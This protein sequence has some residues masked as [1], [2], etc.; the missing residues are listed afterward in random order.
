MDASET[1]QR[2]PPIEDYAAIGNCHTVALVSRAGSID[3]WCPLRFDRSAVFAALLDVER[4]GRFQICPTAPFEVRRRYL[5]R[6]NVLE[7][8]FSTRQGRLR[9]IDWMPLGV[10][11]E[12]ENALQ[13][14]HSILRVVECTAGSVEVQLTY[15]PRFDYGKAVP[16]IEQKTYG[17]RCM[18]GAEALALRSELP[19]GI[20]PDGQSVQGKATLQ[21]GDRHFVGL[22]FARGEP[23]LLPPL[24]AAAEAL[25]E[26]TRRWW[27]EWAAACSYDGPYR[28]A[29]LRSALALKL[30]TYAPSGAIVAAP[31]TSLPEAV[32]GERNWD[33][34]Y[35]WLRDASLTMRALLGLGY[36][37]EA[38]AFLG[39]LLHATYVT[40][41][42]L[43][44]VYDVFGRTDLEE[45]V[46]DHLSGYR[47]SR[48]VRVGNE[49]GRQFQL[50]L[51]GEVVG[52]A[53]EYIMRGG[54]LSKRR[55]Q[56]LRR[57]GEV[58]CDQWRK[59]DEGIWEV[60]TGRRHYVHSKLMCWRALDNLLTM[61]DHG[62]LS[63]PVERFRREREVIRETIEDEGYSK[64][65]N[66][67]VQAFGNHRADASLL[68]LPLQGYIRP[69]APRMQSTYAFLE[70]QLSADGLWYRYPPGGGDGLEGR[71]GAFGVCSFWAVEYLARA[72]KR[73]V[74][75]EA[76]E[77]V[78]ACANDVGLFAEE[79]DPETGAALGNFPQ[80]FTH[81][82]LVN[83]AL[84]L[85]PEEERAASEQA[86]QDRIQ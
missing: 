75:A 42:R 9:L 13:P 20:A 60:R 46:L 21:H 35:C 71:E 40:W 81:I 53:H 48:P 73:E 59:P 39:W 69:T 49:A 56:S 65:V 85:A 74:A 11:D 16:R 12:G 26:T 82:G 77:R 33:Y 52:A 50:D 66:S 78:L 76:F 14:P 86:P 17:L 3:W 68:L 70:E 79:I 18:R 32:G 31:T 62:H 83:A 36:R 67:Y 6:T 1:Q 61:H 8:T 72:G 30:M 57:L 23:L 44:V 41:P 51:Y 43:Q 64:D 24:G 19:V 63:V 22:T 80:A 45:H 27:E 29:V 10:S 58:V 34:R 54:R 55:V 4:G 84:A 38:Q 37:V 15:E 28:E 5:D 47:G 7:T 2:P 25:L